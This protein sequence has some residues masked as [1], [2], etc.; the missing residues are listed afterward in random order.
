VAVRGDQH[1]VV[2]KAV[3]GRRTVLSLDEVAAESRV[4]EVARLLGG[5]AAE[6]ASPAAQVAYARELLAR[7]P[8]S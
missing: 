2:R 4:E 3:R 1:W 5:A 7:A 8:T 6:T